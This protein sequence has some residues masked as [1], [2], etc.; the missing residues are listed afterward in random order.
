VIYS[1][2]ESSRNI[3]FIKAGGVDITRLKIDSLKDR[4]DQSDTDED[5]NNDEYKQQ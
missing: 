3:Y 1:E 5:D 2:K 4:N